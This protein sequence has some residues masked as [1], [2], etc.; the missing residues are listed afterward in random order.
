MCEGLS[1]FHL[2]MGLGVQGYRGRGSAL[3]TVLGNLKV[4]GLGNLKIVVWDFG[5][6]WHHL[7]N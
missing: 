1:Q 6:A 4:K 5:A 3:P 7:P 2:L